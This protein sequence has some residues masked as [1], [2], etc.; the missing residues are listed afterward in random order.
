MEARSLGGRN[1]RGGDRATG[2][3]LTGAGCKPCRAGQAQGAVIRRVVLQ[4]QGTGFQSIDDLQFAGRPAAPLPAVAPVVKV[5]IR[6]IGGAGENGA[7][8]SGTVAGDDLLS[9]AVLEW[10]VARPPGSNAPTVFRS[11]VQLQGTARHGPSPC[12]SS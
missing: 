5:S 3:A 8:V 9:P 7:T 1:E 12:L 6:D 2:V 10:Q 11:S 4:Y